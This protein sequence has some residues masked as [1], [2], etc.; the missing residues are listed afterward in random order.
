MQNGSRFGPDPSQPVPTSGPV[1]TSDEPPTVS[2]LR[3][4]TKVLHFYSETPRETFTEDQN[5]FPS[6]PLEQESRREK[7]DTMGMNTS[8]PYEMKQYGSFFPPSLPF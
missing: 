7:R 5:L 3:S 6:L 4:S 2:A 8:Y 1:P